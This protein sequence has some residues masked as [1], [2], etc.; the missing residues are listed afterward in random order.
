MKECSSCGKGQASGF[1]ERRSG[2]DR[3]RKRSGAVRRLL[4]PGR[5]SALRRQE[6]RR[7]IYLFDVYNP[8]IFYTVTIIL[9]LSVT[10]AF[11]TLWLL[12]D[13]ATELNPV[14][15]YFLLFGPM[16]F[17]AVKYAL[18]SASVVI[19]VL[20]NYVVIQ[21]IRFPM[22]RLLNY[23]AGCFAIVVVWELFLIFRS[24]P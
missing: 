13:G 11:L 14:M 17:M 3:R 18:T 5:R 2:V 10:D 24:M 7:R 23:F 6:D 8:R 21:H 4:I 12:G 15:A 1:I 9:L 16:V 20:L 19:V 22:G